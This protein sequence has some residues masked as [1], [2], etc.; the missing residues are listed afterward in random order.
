ML[1]LGDIL[2]HYVLVAVMVV[3]TKDSRVGCS[4]LESLVLISITTILL[5][6]YI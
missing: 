5:I 4:A 1:I 2:R 6:K 3:L